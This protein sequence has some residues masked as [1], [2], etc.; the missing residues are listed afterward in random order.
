MEQP[1]PVRPEFDICDISDKWFQPFDQDAEE[2]QQRAEP[3]GESSK[4]SDEITFESHAE[5]EGESSEAQRVRVVKDP[6][7]PTAQEIAEHEITHLPHRSWCPSCVAGRARDR[8]HR[9]QAN[10]GANSVPTVVFD[11]G[12]MG[13]EGEAETTPILVVRDV[14]SKM[15]FSHVVQR[16]G[17]I[18]DHGVRQLVRDIE[19]LGYH[20]VC[21]K[22]DGE[23]ALTSM[24]HEV[25]KRRQFDTILE[26]S[27]VGDSQSN[28]IAERAVQSVAQQIRV[29]RHSLQ[30][31]M[32]AVLP[33]P[34]PVTCWLVE[35]ASDLLNKYQLGEDG[36]TAYQRLRGK[37]WSRDVVEFGEKVHYRMNLK[38]LPREQ[39]LEPRWEEGFFLGVK[40]RTG[41]CWIGTPTGVVRASAIRRV[42]GHRRWD[43]QGLLGVKGVPWDHVQKDA[44]PGE[45]R[46]TWLDPNLLAKPDAAPDG[47]PRR[48][49]VYLQRQDFYKH[50]FS[51]DC[52]GCKAIIN[53]WESRPHTESCRT[54]MEQC[55][56]SSDISKA[57]V[58]RAKARLDEEMVRMTE[59]LIDAPEGQVVKRARVTEPSPKGASASSSSHNTQGPMVD[60]SVLSHSKR[61]IESEP[62]PVSKK[63][64]GPE[65]DTDMLGH[66][67]RG[68]ESESE[69]ADKRPKSQQPDMDVG[70]TC[71]VHEP[72]QTPRRRGWTGCQSALKSRGRES[73]ASALSLPSCGAS[74]SRPILC[75]G[76]ESSLSDIEPSRAERMMQEDF[77]WR[78]QSVSTMCDGDSDVAK[79]ALADM[80]YFDENTGERL[81][82]RLVAEG[83]AEELGRFAKMGVYG[84]ADRAAAQNDQEGVFVNVKWVRVNKGT[85]ERPQ[86][87]CRLVAQELGYGTRMD[88]LYA[89]T[90]SLFCVKM[91]MLHAAQEGKGRKLMT[92]DVKSAFL[93]GAARRKI[94]I[95][96]P[97]ADP[98]AGGDKVGVLHKALYG[99]RDAPQIWQHEIRRVLKAAGF[100]QSA[101]QPSVYIHDVRGIL[102]VVHVDDFLI[103]GDPES[104]EWLF[105]ALSAEWDLKRCVLSSSPNDAHETSYLNRRLKWNVHNE[106]SYEGDRKHS[107]RLL[108]DWGLVKGKGVNSPLTHP[109][110]EGVGNGRVLSDSEGRRVRQSIARINFMCQDRPDLCYVSRLMSKY[111]SAPTEGTRDALVH[112]IRYIK[113]HPRCVNR[114]IASV[115]AS[116]F[117]LDVFCD[118]DWANCKTDRKS[119][120][121]GV[122]LMAGVPL[123]F[124]SK[125][126]SNIALSSGEAELNSCV[127]AV[128]ECLGVVNL[129][130]ELFDQT[131][132]SR[133]HVD[134]S[135][136]KGMVLRAGSGKVKHL[137]TKQLWVQAA[138]EA[139]GIT[140]CKI[141]RSDNCADMLTHILPGK[142]AAAQLRTLGFQHTD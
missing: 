25:V 43:A 12:F 17:L 142:H 86:V 91:A 135:A 24:Q 85:R 37:V 58:L 81:D 67:K 83:E 45:V 39:K 3:S 118:S 90:P 15:L 51:S 119:C 107:D 72:S 1:P 34:H 106:L 101:A 33:G 78:L 9:R 44:R 108:H 111:M 35:H 97:S 41:E 124:W 61:G 65:P 47:P 99:T 57:K 4:E 132:P 76:G 55:L 141:P 32:G 70:L 126:Q 113:S 114:F 10:R 7:K 73:S 93:Y 123:C 2:L 116:G 29:M 109:L 52:A 6:G 102:L 120:S 46:V 8:P 104:L 14:D 121:G 28:G 5:L 53:G 13:A 75:D 71:V 64:K 82:P 98:M 79:R 38:N 140:V 100:R 74:R 31:K 48:R 54:R 127:K 40:W 62:E 133:I 130:E 131:L 30:Q 129:W 136:C 49:R 26:N 105:D 21:L 122:V 134:S 63:P 125:T 11:Y 88:E 117:R 59:P 138:T 20:K 84:Y 89:N 19:R 139:H 42:G 36:R 69:S 80:T 77:E 96:L 94:Y 60:A 68:A 66:P 110:E 87:K 112:V 128:S 27:P 16:K 50:G 22:C 18:A 23:P 56:E 92:L 103:S 95:E 137:S 115:P